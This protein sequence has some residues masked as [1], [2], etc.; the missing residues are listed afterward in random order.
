MLHDN[1]LFY[2]W[3]VVNVAF[4]LIS[5]HLNG[6]TANHLKYSDSEEPI[7]K[8]PFQ[9]HY[10]PKDILIEIFNMEGVAKDSANV[11]KY[12]E[13][14]RFSPSVMLFAHITTKERFS[15]YLKPPESASPYMKTRFIFWLN[16]HSQ[17]L[18]EFLYY[19]KPIFLGFKKFL[20]HLLG[21]PD[22]S[23]IENV[24]IVP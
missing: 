22:I 14:I 15:Y 2:F 1:K 5:D 17:K 7:K 3:L 23:Q 11:C 6:S 9:A 18:K 13:E 4:V 19:R 10:L 24:H 21:A 20:F 12:W 16:P 8:N